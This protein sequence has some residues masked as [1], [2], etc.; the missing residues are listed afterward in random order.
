[1]DKDI[2]KRHTLMSF[3][4]EGRKYRLISEMISDH[5]DIEMSIEQHVMDSKTR[6]EVWIKVSPELADKNHMTIEQCAVMLDNI[7]KFVNV[8]FFL[9]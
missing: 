4:Y 1:M 7:S 2:I 3:E 8:N 5:G 9:V 6:E